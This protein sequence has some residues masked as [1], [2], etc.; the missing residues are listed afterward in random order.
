M[1][2]AAWV[3]GRVLPLA[4]ATLPVTDRGF[5]LGDAVFETLRRMDAM[6]DGAGISADDLRDSHPRLDQAPTLDQSA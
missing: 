1:D 4:Q 2:G 5:L 3:D 6:N